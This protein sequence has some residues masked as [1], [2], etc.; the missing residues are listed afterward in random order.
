MILLEVVE[1][2]VL[3]LPRQA[4]GDGHGVPGH[5]PQLGNQGALVFRIEP[6]VVGVVVVVVAAVIAV[7]AVGPPPPGP[8]LPPSPC[9]AFRDEVPIGRH[10]S[11]LRR[12]RRRRRRR[13]GGGLRYR[14]GPEIA[15]SRALAWTSTTGLSLPPIGRLDDGADDDDDAVADDSGGR[16]GHRIV[17]STV[18]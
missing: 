13:R 11:R 1:E 9:D 12:R 4:G 17:F 14:A 7:A 2:G 8:L 6:P 16:F 3:E 10:R 18:G 5:E 15:P